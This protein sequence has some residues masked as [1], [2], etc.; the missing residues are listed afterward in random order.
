MLAQ[1]W[2]TGDLGFEVRELDRAADGHVASALFVRHVNDGAAGA[3]RWVVEQLFHGQHRCARNVKLAQDVHRFV[4]GLVFQPVFDGG[5]DVHDVRL[6]CLGRGVSRIGLPFRFAQSVANRFPGVALHCEIDVSVGVGLP[7]FALENP[8]RL[9]AAAGVAAAW[10]HVRKALVRVLWILFQVAQFVQAQL[11]THLDAAQVEHGVLH[12]DS[13]FLA[14][15]GLLAAD[16][17]RQDADGQ[18]HAGVAVAQGGSRDHGAGLLAFP[19]AGGGGCAAG[20]LG[21][22]FVDLQVFVVVAVAEALDRSQD[23][24]GVEFLNALPGKAHAVQRAGAEVLDQH[25]AFLDEFF[26]NGLAFRLFGVQ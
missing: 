18:V 4:L 3:Q 10:H 1:Q 5:E 14:F 2:R 26:Q 6:A 23:H 20:A 7:A 9:T 19:P 16:V 17:G 24:L 21:H 12:G 15:A 25:I 22:V 13:H 8:A 11:V